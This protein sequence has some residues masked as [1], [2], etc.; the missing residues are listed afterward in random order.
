MAGLIKSTEC[1]VG[2]DHHEHSGSLPLSGQNSPPSPTEGRVKNQESK[3]RGQERR[4]A[5]RKGR[6]GGGGGKG[7]ETGGRREG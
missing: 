6:R 4:R 5:G 1:H 3:Q 2:H 7:E